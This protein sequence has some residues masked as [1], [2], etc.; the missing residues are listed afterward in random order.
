MH[1]VSEH[2][3]DWDISVQQITYGYS[4]QNRRLT[5]LTP[6]SLGLSIHPP[7]STPFESSS[8]LPI[9]GMHAIGPLTLEEVIPHC[10]AVMLE[11]TD[12]NLTAVQHWYRDRHDGQVCATGSFEILKSRLCVLLTGSCSIQRLH[13]HWIASK[14]ATPKLG[15][16]R[17]PLHHSRD[18]EY[19]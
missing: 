3:C 6:L 17:N 12:R 1:Y 14:T 2:Q 18:C 4:T 13:G 10:I 9:D 15:P 8:E 11:K 19:R 16:I 5:R 7:G